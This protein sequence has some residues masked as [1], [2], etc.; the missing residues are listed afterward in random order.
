MKKVIAALDNSLAAGPVMATAVALARLLDAEVDALH[1]RVDGEEVA[2]GAA[3]AVGLP[4]GEATGSP[5]EELIA[6]TSP[7]DV[8][9]L[10]LG[11]RGRPLGA[12]PL[13]ATALAVAT[14]VVKPVVVV[15]PDAVRPGVLQRVLVP[16]EGTV[17]TSLAPRSVVDLACSANLDVVALHVH[18]EADLP[19]FSDQPQ[20][21]ADAWA[22]EFLAR[23]CPQGLDRAEFEVRVGRAEELVPLVAEQ[24]EADLIA[25]GWA[26][27]LAEGRAPVVRAALTR[28]RVPVMLLPA[29]VREPAHAGSFH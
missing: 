10:V 9:A 19:A 28:A 6:A 20:H 11:A 26:Q 17:S 27:E 23:W 14:S 4:L 18:D 24:V 25:L 5:I 7:D 22:R 29:L 12:R 2:L 3:E 1:V 13:G 21:E 16:L 15:P 8:V